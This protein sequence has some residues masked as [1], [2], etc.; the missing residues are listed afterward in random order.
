[1]TEQQTAT[2]PRVAKPPGAGTP[3]IVEVV[4]R[5]TPSGGVEFSQKW[6]W[7]DGTPGGG[8]RIDIPPRKANEPGTPIHFHLKDETQPR[9]GFDFT[10]EDEGPMW[11]KRGSC[12][13]SDQR[14]E[15]PQ[16]PPGKMKR[17]P[18]LLKVFDENSEACTLHYRLRFKDRQG[19]AE[20][21]DPDIR[22]GGGK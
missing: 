10:D 12:P 14:C 11:V 9:R 17:S 1:M 15:D 4:A 18:N 21:F 20:S 22:N 13:P 16:I 2:A 5:S 3:V 8:N 19:R 7:E 6:R